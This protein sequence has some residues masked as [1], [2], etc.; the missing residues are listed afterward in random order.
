[1]VNEPAITTNFLVAAFDGLVP[2]TSFYFLVAPHC[3][4]IVPVQITV[5]FGPF[6]QVSM[7]VLGGGVMAVTVTGT[8]PEPLV[9]V[10]VMVAVVGVF[11]AV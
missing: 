9:F 6:V 2:P 10:P 7:N 1:M 8:L 11:G 3:A 4:G 5:P